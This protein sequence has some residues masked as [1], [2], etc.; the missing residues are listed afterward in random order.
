MPVLAFRNPSYSKQFRVIEG[1]T[2]I[3]DKIKSLEYSEVTVEEKIESGD[4]DHF[5]DAFLI[6]CR[7]LTEWFTSTTFISRNLTLTFA[8]YQLGE[9]PAHTPIYL[10]PGSNVSYT[11]RIWS[12]TYQSKPPFF[13]IFDS[14]NAY[15]A[16]VS[17]DGDI[18]RALFHQNLS[19]GSVQDPKVTKI[20][21][22]V[23]KYSYY[24]MTGYADAGISYQFNVTDNVQY[25]NATDYVS[26]YS[27]CH[28]SSGITCTFKTSD[29]FFG[30]ETQQCLVAH[31]HKPIADDPPS[32]HIVI[33][34]V[35]GYNLLL[36]PGVVAVVSISFV[37]VI[38]TP[39]VVSVRRR[40]KYRRGYASIQ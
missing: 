5:I 26:K 15:E 25:L 20:N 10:L 27:V 21:F 18:S 24:Y 17:G 37:I 38:V 12:S 19:I 39:V 9:Q 1:D 4:S 7:N 36:V 8:T 32:T 13:A 28:F 29:N 2:V 6:P 23:K 34:V 31:I 40:S 14:Y 35:K 16:F 22:P 30:T 11:F 33:N 3:L